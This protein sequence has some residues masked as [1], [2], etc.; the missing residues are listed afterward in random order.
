MAGL[1][2]TELLIIAAVIMVLFGAKRLPDSARAL[3]RSL[4][5]LKAEIRGMHDDSPAAPVEASVQPVTVPT[6][7]AERRRWSTTPPASVA[8]ALV[9]TLPVPCRGRPE[10]TSR[11]P[12]PNRRIKG[13]WALGS[14]HPGPVPSWRSRAR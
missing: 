5:I 9:A 2:T 8:C 7:A 12:G 13:R 10:R 1:G 3:G 11:Y 14:S 6:T 4:R